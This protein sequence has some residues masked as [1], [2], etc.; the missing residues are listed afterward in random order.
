MNWKC[1][2][3]E[4]PRHL[5]GGIEE[6]HENLQSGQPVSGPRFGTAT[7]LVRSRGANHSTA[8]FGG[9]RKIVL[10]FLMLNNQL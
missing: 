5:H 2:N 4:L 7:S 9:N 3:F 1:L 6:I 10:N 8:G